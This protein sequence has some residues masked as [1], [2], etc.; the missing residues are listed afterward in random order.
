MSGRIVTI[1]IIIVA[2]VL[3]VLAFTQQ[4]QAA[5]NEATAIARADAAG[6]A[7]ADA[8][9][10]RQT[11]VMDANNQATAQ[12]EAQDSEG[13][14]V[15]G[16]NDA[17]TAQ[18]QAEAT[19]S[20]AELAAENAGA[21]AAAAL[22]EASAQGGTAAAALAEATDQ[23]ESAATAQGEAAQQESTAVSLVGQLTE[24]AHQ[25]ATQN[26]QSTA[27]FALAQSDW[28][29]SE[30]H[31]LAT[32]EAAQAQIEVIE[33]TATAH[34]E[35]T[36]TGIAQFE[37]TVYAYL[38]EG[39]ATPTPST[40]AIQPFT[41][42]A[43]DTEYTT[44]DGSLTISYPSQWIVSETSGYVVLSSSRRATSGFSGVPQGEMNILVLR[45][46]AQGLSALG[47][48]LM[49]SIV[50][51][52]LTEQLQN[53]Y[54]LEFSEPEPFQ[55]GDFDAARSIS[56]TPFGDMEVIGYFNRDVYI[57][58]VDIC[59][60]GEG[61]ACEPVLTAIAKRIVYHP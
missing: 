11:A 25:L 7:G 60:P 54:S 18:A 59:A 27:D 13:T 34:V 53:Q 23:A 56:S 50:T 37:A 51:D 44:N 14:A 8:E 21:T 3:V 22:S 28:A 6:T 15:A 17:M 36:A 24:A 10:V 52:G 4:Q 32:A 58:A 57:I 41:V 12:A 39:A 33:A 42:P 5:N 16:A 19:R 61:S 49:L 40:G 43:L 48:E 30:A 47:P 31:L 45:T 2:L 55:L 29:T 1:G 20:A 38:T 26:S 46:Q 35:G 9:A